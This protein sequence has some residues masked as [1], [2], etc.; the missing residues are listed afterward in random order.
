MFLYLGRY[1][2]YDSSPSS[3]FVIDTPVISI[4]GKSLLLSIFMIPMPGGSLDPLIHYTCMVVGKPL[5]N[6]VQL[7]CF[8]RRK[9]DVNPL[10]TSKI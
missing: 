8:S 4:F 10:K 2:P 7:T 1:Q 5:D 3:T 9:K 6:I